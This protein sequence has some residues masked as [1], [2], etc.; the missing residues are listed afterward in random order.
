[1]RY[2]WIIVLI[3]MPLSVQAKLYG[4]INYLMQKGVASWFY[5]N[6]MI[7]ASNVYPVGTYLLVTNTENNKSVEVIVS[8]TGPFIIGRIL[9]L[10]SLAADKIEMKR[11]GIV[12]VT[13][14]PLGK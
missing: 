7:A 2:L 13:I 14:Q 3:F 10:S 5:A 11:H 4:P 8:G 9:D 1:M 6:G 12:L